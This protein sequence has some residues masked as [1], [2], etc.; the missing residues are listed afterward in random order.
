M[1]EKSKQKQDESKKKEE[2]KDNWTSEEL[3]LLS[4][5]IVKYPGALPN[6]WKVITEHIGT[7]KTQKQVIAKAQELAQRTS[8]AKAGKEKPISSV[9]SS[10]FAQKEAKK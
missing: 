9:Q 2:V 6:R 10:S 1:A 7:G 5:A 4:K 3:S 8:L